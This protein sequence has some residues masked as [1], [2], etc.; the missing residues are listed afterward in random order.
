MSGK[1]LTYIFGAGSSKDF[2]FPLGNEIFLQAERILSD[3]RITAEDRTEL[4][5]AVKEVDQIMRQIYSGLPADKSKYPLFEEVMTF[6][7]QSKQYETQDWSNKKKLGAWLTLFDKRSREILQDFVKMLVMMMS[8]A[9]KRLRFRNELLL[10]ETFIKSLKLRENN[11][12]I[13]SLNYDLLIDTILLK[14]SNEGVI[15]DFNYG[16]PLYSMTDGRL[17]RNGG[18]SLLKPHG[19]LNLSSSTGN[20][21][22]TYYHYSETNSA[23][24]IIQGRVTSCPDPHNFGH[25]YRLKPLII[26]PLYMKESYTK[27]SQKTQVYERRRGVRSIERGVLEEY[28]NWYVDRSISDSLEKADELTIVGY[29]MP[30]YDFDFKSLLING[31]MKNRRRQSVPVYIISKGNRGQLD[32][33]KAR[34][35]HLAGE[36]RFIG[37]K[38]FLNYLKEEVGTSK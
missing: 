35:Q 18:V 10:Y 4:E 6:I 15:K 34:F 16:V 37:E 22:G 36:V 38:G 23:V 2:G 9:R 5:A 19:S 32:D 13:I 21:G 7:W 1:N 14:C 3:A 26:P 30:A 24:D 27:E 28:R 31:L 33:L 17:C 12:S 25:C 8:L 11:V 29:S 20:E